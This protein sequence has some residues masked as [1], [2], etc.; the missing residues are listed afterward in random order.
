MIFPDYENINEERICQECYGYKKGDAELSFV[1]SLTNPISLYF[2]LLGRYTAA[3]GKV[4]LS[5]SFWLTSMQFFKYRL[6][7]RDLRRK[8]LP[9]ALKGGGKL[10][11][12]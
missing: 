11:E 9:K 3:A 2:L 1:A 4:A 10:L 7:A 6:T 8:N 5:T 12:E